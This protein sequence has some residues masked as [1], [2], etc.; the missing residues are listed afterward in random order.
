MP[1]HLTI[2]TS[3]KPRTLLGRLHRHRLR[4]RLQRLQRLSSGGLAA[5]RLVP[6]RGVDLQLILA[7]RGTSW[8]LRYFMGPVTEQTWMLTM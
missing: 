3:S 2:Q 5:A 6:G 4:L 8:E 7:V 1:R